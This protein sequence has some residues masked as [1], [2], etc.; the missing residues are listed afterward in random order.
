MGPSATAGGFG[1]RELSRGDTIQKG[2]AS[3]Y[4]PDFHGK[5]TANGEV[6]DMED[7][8]AAHKTL[9][10]NT[11]VRVENLRNGKKVEV[12]INDRGPYVGDRVI[13]L[14]KKAAADIDMIGPGTAPVR[15]VLLKEGDAPV[16]PRVIREELFTVQIASYQDRREAM[17][18]A[19]GIR[20][21]TVERRMA[22]GRTVYRV[23]YGTF[24]TREK[25]VAALEKLNRRGINGFV[26]QYQN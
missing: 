22:D 2:T 11:I 21:A 6:Y 24:P 10:F 16:I 15:L 3:W 1:G 14:S 8:T 18:K 9:P 4:G 20:G 12:R 19:E 25:A 13:D 17:N 5:K 26:K 7:L 23:I